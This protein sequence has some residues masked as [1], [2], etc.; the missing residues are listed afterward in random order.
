MYGFSVSCTTRP[1]R[2]GEV[3]GVDYNFLTDDQF[4]AMIK[5]DEFVEW[6]QARAARIPAHTLTWLVGPALFGDDDVAR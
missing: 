3:D 1:P 4:D 2:A 5:R 6:A